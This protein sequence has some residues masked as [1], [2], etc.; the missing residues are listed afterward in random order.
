LDDGGLEE[1]EEVDGDGRSE[2]DEVG[3]L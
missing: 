3:N 2:F 1:F